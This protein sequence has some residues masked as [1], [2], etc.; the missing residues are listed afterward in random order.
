MRDNKGMTLIETMVACVILTILMTVLIQGILAASNW[1]AE[2]N[3]IKDT[4]ETVANRVEGADDGTVTKKSEGVSVKLE[5]GAGSLTLPA[6]ENKKNDFTYSDISYHTMESSVADY[7][8]AAADPIYDPTRV[9]AGTILTICDQI[10]NTYQTEGYK[11]AGFSKDSEYNSND[12]WLKA[13]QKKLGGGN[14]SWPQLS[15]EFIEKYHISDVDPADK[16]YMKAYVYGQDPLEVLIYV[17]NTPGG[18]ANQWRAFLIY[19]PASKLWYRCPKGAEGY[20]FPSYLDEKIGMS[21]TMPSC[22]SYSYYEA[23]NYV[24]LHANNTD[25]IN[26]M[27]VTGY[28]SVLGFIRNEENGWEALFPDE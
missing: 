14:G 12:G 20:A 4:G 13:I 19:D 22:G 10:N 23:D 24:Y 11:A 15:S 5:D 27:Q 25:T 1:F 7:E 17:T 8:P 26:N 9:D 28:A 6:T 18:G 3:R 2:S 21:M 16:L